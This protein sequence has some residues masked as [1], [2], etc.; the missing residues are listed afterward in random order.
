M[1]I[2][3][4]EGRAVCVCECTAHRGQGRLSS[5]PGTDL[6]ARVSRLTHNWSLVIWKSRSCSQL[7]N[8]LQPL[9]C[10]AL[11]VMC[12]MWLGSDQMLIIYKMRL[13]THMIAY[14]NRITCESTKDWD[15]PHWLYH[16]AKSQWCSIKGNCIAALVLSLC[17][18]HILFNICLH[19]SMLDIPCL[20]G[21]M[22]SLSH[23]VLFF[24]FPRPTPSVQEL[25][26]LG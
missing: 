17:E 21:W 25:L 2:R 12:F 5:P 18:L 24:C 20:D 15:M 14:T 7:L 11:T 3:I 13:H 6:Q 26:H 22:N 8:P 4:H 16:R 1:F 23:L 9:N 10:D 19:L